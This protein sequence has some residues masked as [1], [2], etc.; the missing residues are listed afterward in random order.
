MTYSTCTSAGLIGSIQ[1]DGSGDSLTVGHLDHLE[2][3]RK[4]LSDKELQDKVNIM[5][6]LYTQMQK[7]NDELIKVYSTR[8]KSKFPK[9]ESDLRMIYRNLER[10]IDPNWYPIINA[11]EEPSKI[12]QKQKEIVKDMI[13][14]REMLV[15]RVIALYPELIESEHLKDDDKKMLGNQLST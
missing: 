9:T 3:I 10:L 5:I 15:R 6:N 11:E 2:E 12:I 1:Y 4:A 14:T 7:L 8:T 13:E